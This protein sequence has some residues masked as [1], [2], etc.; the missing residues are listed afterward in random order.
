MNI[1]DKE[2]QTILDN[3]FTNEKKWAP[4]NFFKTYCAVFMVGL[5]LMLLLF[6][7][8]SWEDDFSLYIFFIIYGFYNMGFSLYLSRFTNYPTS[9]GTIRT[10]YELTKYMPVSK[11]QLC[12]FGIK[13][14]LK[15]CTILTCGIIIFRFICSYMVFH[16]LSIWDI[17]EPLIICTILPILLG[18]RALLFPSK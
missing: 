10:L 11:V 14:I 12:L 16:R 13:K 3:F 17:F 1:F 4:N 8:I 15:P 2:Q 7:H 18:L 6:P 5:S 9:P